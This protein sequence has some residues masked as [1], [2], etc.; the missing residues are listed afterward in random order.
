MV[1][2]PEVRTE[3]NIKTLQSMHRSSRDENGQNVA[4]S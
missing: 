4:I 1:T 3:A 2:T